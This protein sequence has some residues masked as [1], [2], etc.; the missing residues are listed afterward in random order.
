MGSPRSDPKPHLS[1]KLVIRNSPHIKHKWLLIPG[2][3]HSENRFSGLP[4]IA[5]RRQRAERFV[6]GVARFRSHRFG[7]HADRRLQPLDSFA[8]HSGQ[9]VHMANEAGAHFII[10][11]H[12]QTFRFSAEGFREPIERF[13][14]ALRETPERIA[15]REIGETFV[16]PEMPIF[17]SPLSVHSHEAIY[18]RSRRPG[19]AGQAVQPHY[20]AAPWP[21]IAPPRTD[22]IPIPPFAIRF[23]AVA[24][25]RAA[26]QSRRRLPRKKRIDREPRE[27]QI[28]ALNM[29]EQH[30]AQVLKNIGRRQGPR[31]AGSGVE[32]GPVREV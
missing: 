11:V 15:L 3:P 27:H 4:P 19:S 12:H 17:R 21:D 1:I 23:P 20:A 29:V 25:W 31:P 2:K 22:T 18:A 9:A 10:S 28:G 24:R 32:E 14:A 7:D 6:C 13:Q 8:L 30:A 5:D 26:A 16:L